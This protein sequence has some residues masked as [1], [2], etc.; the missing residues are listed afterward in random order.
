MG[1]R[2]RET[3]WQISGVCRKYYVF[4]KG[5]ELN[6]TTHSNTTIVQIRQYDRSV[7]VG[8]AT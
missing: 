2:D 3:R 7:R 8:E 1:I 4:R 6:D 5:G